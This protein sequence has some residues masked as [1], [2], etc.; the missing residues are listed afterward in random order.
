[1]RLAVAILLGWAWSSWLAALL[2]EPATTDPVDAEHRPTATRR[3]AI[4]ML[5]EHRHRPGVF[6][7]GHCR[8]CA[9]QADLLDHYHRVQREEDRLRATQRLASQAHRTAT[10]ALWASG[11]GLLLAA[12][13]LLTG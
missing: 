1:M 13:A 3:R 6:D 8:T 4:T 10:W 12:I 9:Q 2:A 11:I 5:I 7:P